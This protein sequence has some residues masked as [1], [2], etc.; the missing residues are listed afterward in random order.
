MHTDTMTT[1][2]TGIITEAD[3]ERSGHNFVNKFIYLF[4]APFLLLVIS[5]QVINL[6]VR[7]KIAQYHSHRGMQ[8]MLTYCDACAL[9]LKYLVE[10]CSEINCVK[11]YIFCLMIKRFRSK[12]T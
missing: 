10:T 1:S 8:S 9:S 7:T 12:I 6:S 11:L 4:D 2:A 3:S 5:T